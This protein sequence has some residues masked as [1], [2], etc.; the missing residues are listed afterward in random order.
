[1]ATTPIIEADMNDDGRC[2]VVS[3]QCKVAIAP[4]TVEHAYHPELKGFP[5]PSSCHLEA[6]GSSWVPGSW[7]TSVIPHLLVTEINRGCARPAR[8]RSC[9]ISP[10]Q[11]KPTPS[12]SEYDH[13]VLHE[14]RLPALKPQGGMIY[15]L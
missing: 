2:Y 13:V 7:Y 9:S 11:R 4:G 3:G 1:M 5:P 14:P 12:H 6:T 15:R 10:A 8:A